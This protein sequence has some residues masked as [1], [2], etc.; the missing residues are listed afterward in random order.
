MGQ[1]PVAFCASSDCSALCYTGT[2]QYRLRPQLPRH[3]TSGKYVSLRILF[4]CS[5]VANPPLGLDLLV[6][7]SPENSPAF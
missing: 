1:Y 4:S 7:S 5:H 6:K 3:D 2:P